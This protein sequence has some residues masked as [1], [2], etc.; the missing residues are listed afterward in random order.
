MQKEKYD[1]F[2][3][4]SRKDYVDEKKN[5]IPD[6]V[7]SK[8][9]EALTKA[10]IT[11]W[12]DEEG[13]YCGQNFVEKIVTNIENA[14]IFLF[15]STANSN[16]SQWTC[17]EIATADKLG[18][19]IIP[20]R[21]DTTPYN[22]NV[23]FR[24]ADLDY[25]DYYTNP[26]KGLVDL[27]KSINSYLDEFFEVE[28]TN[29]DKQI[30]QLNSEL[31]KSQSHLAEQRMII[32]H[33]KE[34]I[35][36]LQKRLRLKAPKSSIIVYRIAL[37]F[38]LIGGSFLL[39][40]SQ[41]RKQ[42]WMNRY[43]E[44][45]DDLYELKEAKETL[46]TLSSHMPFIITDIDIKNKNEEWGGKLYCEKITYIFPRIKYIGIKKGTYHMGIKIYNP[47]GTL[48]RNVEIS[49]EGYTYFD[50]VLIEDGVNFSSSITG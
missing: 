23:L 40:E 20:I 10:E 6:N 38:I 17:K 50:D 42:Y 27:L 24:I 8:I 29:K 34:Q 5:V 33:L 45:S 21:I 36:D 26:Q 3:S 47:D 44:V 2:I 28:I 41:S 25:I 35:G 14:K 37:I 16:K 31:E 4:Y 49:P 11:Y 46:N 43:S 30:L 48:K 19:H 1:V 7:V 39:Y 32:G 13:I 15:L 22:K 18:K 9:K 12:F